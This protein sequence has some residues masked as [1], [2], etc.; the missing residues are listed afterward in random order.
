MHNP[1]SVEVCITSILSNPNPSENPAP[2][3][4]P[5][6]YGTLNFHSQ[7]AATSMPTRVNDA[8]AMAAQTMTFSISTKRQSNEITMTH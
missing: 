4:D 6:K 3:F 5:L 8:L 2:T 1:G 7:V